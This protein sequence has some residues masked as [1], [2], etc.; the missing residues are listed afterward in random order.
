MV[1]VGLF[2]SRYLVKVVGSLRARVACEEMRVI[3]SV[4]GATTLSWRWGR[5]LVLL[6]EIIDVPIAIV[7]RSLR[8]TN[9]GVVNVVVGITL[10]LILK[11][12]VGE[13]LPVHM[14]ERGNVDD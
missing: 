14:H 12:E 11:T 2:V 10:Q 6:Y 7:Y 1:F 5:V 3:S 9:A 13:A 8:E 4:R